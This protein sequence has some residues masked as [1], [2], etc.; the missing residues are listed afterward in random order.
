MKTVGNY[1]CVGKND[2]T[3]FDDYIINNY[4]DKNEKFKLVNK[5]YNFKDFYEIKGFYIM[6]GTDTSISIRTNN[7]ETIEA[8]EVQH[9]YLYD[10]ITEEE[11]KSY[12]LRYNLISR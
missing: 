12:C 2:I 6:N 3:F 11:Y 1:R 9:N 7:I 4:D 10:K 5:D 8:M